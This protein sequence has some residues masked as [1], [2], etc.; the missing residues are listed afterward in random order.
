MFDIQVCGSGT[1]VSA[2][3]AAFTNHYFT[4]N[5]FEHSIIVSAGEWADSGA[6]VLG[7]LQY[8]SQVGREV[9]LERLGSAI[10]KSIS[11]DL[12]I[13]NFYLQSCLDIRFIYILKFV[14]I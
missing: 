11:T 12:L 10:Q 7:L 2:A 13:R 9:V 6:V 3:L 5:A 8:N 1:L 4:I 14:H